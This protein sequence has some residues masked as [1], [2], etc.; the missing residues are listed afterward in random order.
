[1]NLELIASGSGSG[2]SIYALPGV[3]EFLD[4]LSGKDEE[5]TVAML[6]YVS[7]SGTPRNPQKCNAEGE[8][9]FA[10][11]PGRVRLIFF[12]DSEHRRVIVITHGYMKQGQK[13]P[14]REFRKAEQLRNAVLAAR[15]ERNLIYEGLAD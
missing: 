3:R 6:E 12:Y 1:L 9:F 10:L 15:K 8:G 11:K 14:R 13:M 7:E 2:F 5:A 4:D